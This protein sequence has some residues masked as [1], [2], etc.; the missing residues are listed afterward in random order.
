M[1]GLYMQEHREMPPIS[2]SDRGRIAGCLQLAT[3]GAT[4]GEQ[5][6]GLAGARRLLQRSG[7]S[8]SELVNSRPPAYGQPAARTASFP[9]RLLAEECLRKSHALTDWEA[10]FLESIRS[11]RR[12][13]QKQ[14]SILARI[15]GKLGLDED[16]P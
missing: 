15:A 3:D 7:A 2:E 9:W 11:F 1:A 10:D 6:A 13:S 14:E 8:W 12:L 5:L 4:P 16:A